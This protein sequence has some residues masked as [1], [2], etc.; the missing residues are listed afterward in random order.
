MLSIDLSLIIVFLIVWILLA[1]LNRVFFSPLRKIM[2][3]R[4][5][6]MDQDKRA[7]EAALEL[8]EE[9]SLKVEE[10]LREAKTMA[11]TLREGLMKEG[12]KH[13]ERLLEK[14]N[15]D[16]R[17]QIEAAQDQL[18]RQVKILKNELEV[19]SQNLADQIEKRL[20]S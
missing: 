16:C 7:A 4:Q 12:Q 11:Q 17:S 8:F 2:G 1:V 18:N 10:Q 13:R 15:A 5:D 6:Q 3:S 19:Q 9:E 20:L 14:I